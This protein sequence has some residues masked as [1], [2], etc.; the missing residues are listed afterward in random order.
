MD[1]ALAALAGAA[2]GAVIPSVTNFLL[3]RLK[4]SRDRQKM[5]VDLATAGFAHDLVLAGK[6]GGLVAPL[7]GYVIFYSD[8]LDA[9]A[10]GNVTPDT[11]KALTIR[12]NDLLAA[13]PGAPPLE[14]DDQPGP[15]VAR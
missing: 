4:G 9:I 5:A 13:F 12:K 8:A 14:P 11:I 10:K 7:A 3:Q 2:I 6:R 15:Q 1:A